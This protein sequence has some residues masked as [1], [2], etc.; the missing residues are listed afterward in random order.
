LGFSFDPRTTRWQRD[1]LAFGHGQRMKEIMMI[2]RAQEERDD[3][4]EWEY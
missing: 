4:I 2:M 1:G 3:N